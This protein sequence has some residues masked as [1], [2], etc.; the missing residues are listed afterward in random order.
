MNK[1]KITSSLYRRQ[2][3]LLSK[4]TSDLA[5]VWDISKEA[6]YPSCR[7]GQGSTPGPGATVTSQCPVGAELLYIVQE[8][9]EICLYERTYFVHQHHVVEY[10]SQI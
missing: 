5:T 4:H 10:T 8:L 7:Q 9:I 1:F 3:L 6:W 2:V